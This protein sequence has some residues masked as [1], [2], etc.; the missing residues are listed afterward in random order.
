M[1]KSVL[2]TAAAA[3]VTMILSSSSALSADKTDCASEM[4]TSE[5]MMMK[6]TDQMKKDMVMKEMAMAKEMMAKN[7]EKGCMM[8][9]ENVKKAMIS[10]P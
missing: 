3:I 1:L 10:A 8:H 7:D 6:M 4:K 9:M 5:G 2:T